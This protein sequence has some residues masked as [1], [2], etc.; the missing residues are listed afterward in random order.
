MMGISGRPSSPDGR[1]LLPMEN[2]DVKVMSMGFMVPE[3]TPMI[4]RGPMV[5]SA[6]NQMLRDVEWGELDILVVD[7]PPGTGDAQLTMAQQVPLVGR[8]HRLHAAGH[9]PASMPARGSTCS[10]RSTC[11]CS[12]SSR[13]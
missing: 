7:L 2:Y 1:R 5:M 3:D 10:A 12:A 8:R 11:R 6:I 9:R 13:T 4:W